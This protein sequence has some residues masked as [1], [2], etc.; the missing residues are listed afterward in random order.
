M[1]PWTAMTVRTPSRHCLRTA[2]TTEVHLELTADLVPA[3]D[4]AKQDLV[5][6]D[7]G[8]RERLGKA[9][10]QFWDGVSSSVRLTPPAGSPLAREVSQLNTVLPWFAHDA[11][12]HYLS[13]RGLEQSTGGGWGTRDVCQGPV[14][15]LIALGQ[16]APLRDLIVRVLG[17][18][19]A[20]G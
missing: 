8:A 16:T 13:P 2:P 5:E 18:Q 11:L 3:A 12:V 10:L 19:N 9:P 7:L 20:R 17:A 6:Q 15:L 14:G 4:L 1:W